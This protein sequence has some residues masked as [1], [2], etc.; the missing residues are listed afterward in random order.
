MEIKWYGTATLALS[1]EG[2]SALF[3]PFMSFNQV[4]PRPSLEELIACGDIFITHGHFDHLVIVPEL[5]A[6]GS[7]R[8]FCSQTAAETLKR[9]GVDES[10]ITRIKPGQSIE[11]GTLNIKV[12]R[13]EHIRFDLTLIANTL[14][15]R[16]TLANFNT[17]KQLAKEA[18][19]FPMGEVLA[20]EI[21]TGGK[22]VFHLG[23]L[24]LSPDED[25]PTGADLLSL[26]F[27][28]R[29]DLDLYALQFIDR[30]KPKALLLQHTCDSFPPVSSQVS[31]ESFI[32]KMAE[33]YPAIKVI[34]PLYKQPVTL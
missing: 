32:I 21:G 1:H 29:S 33:Q 31:T 24:N 19:R 26:P 7:Q 11:K 30:L 13:S 22:K 10:R 17:F 3:D 34:K 4:L 15:S 12:Y 9:E 25:Y 2:H 28:G 27:Q 8:V 14:F 5:M 16:R 23:S 20:Y 18:K 6:L